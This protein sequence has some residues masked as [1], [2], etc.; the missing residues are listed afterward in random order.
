MEGGGVHEGEHEVT[1]AE[2]R[3]EGEGVGAGGGGG[4]EDEE[5]DLADV[6]V[7]LEVGEVGIGSEDA[8]YEVVEFCFFPF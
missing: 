1:E 8:D 4:R 3:E 6:V 5:E 7:A 2:V